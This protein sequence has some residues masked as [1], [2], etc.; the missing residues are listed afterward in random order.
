MP[1][2]AANSLAVLDEAL[3]AAHGPTI[4]GAMVGLPIAPGSASRLLRGPSGEAC[5]L[6][7]GSE[8]G[9]CADLKLRNVEARASVRCAIESPDG[10]AVTV[11]GALVTCTAADPQ[12]R[13]LFLN[14]MDEALAAMGPTP[15]AASIA[16]WLHRIATLFAKLEQE[17]RTRLRGLW[18]ELAAMLALGDSA[19]AAR[20]WHTDSHDR[21]DF[22]SGGF[23]IEV[24]SCQ[25]LDRVHHFSLEQLRPPKDLDVWV[26]SV[27]VRADPN[28]QSVLDL[29]HTLEVNISDVPTR[30]GLRA[31]V[32]ASG[33]A[34]LEDDDLHRFDLAG[35]LATLRLVDARAI[36]SINEELPKEVIAITLQVRCRDVTDAG[37]P[38]AALYRLS[39]D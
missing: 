37:T 18:A 36:P 17:G 20:R 7:A 13:R 25:D 14:L 32:L 9:A 16:A 4:P 39:Q 1:E 33:G 3:A 31:M 19:L 34:A 21:F 28:G 29:L 22:L 27:V 12:L 23:A 35:A 10:S 11:K 2:Q 24:K 15:T 38:Q 6:I 5:L 30:D 8:P 26:A